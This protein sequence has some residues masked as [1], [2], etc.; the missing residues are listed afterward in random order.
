MFMFTFNVY[1]YLYVYICICMIHYIGTLIDIV[2][3]TYYGRGWQKLAK[4][5]MTKAIGFLVSNS[6]KYTNVC[7]DVIGNLCISPDWFSGWLLLKMYIH[8]WFLLLLEYASL[9][10]KLHALCIM[11]FT[12][13]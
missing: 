11:H 6:L 10:V 2:C 1:V 12:N 9:T 7:L 13:Y 8:G 5:Q 4:T 3:N